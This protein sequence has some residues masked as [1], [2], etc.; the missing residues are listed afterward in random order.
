M[1]DLPNQGGDCL[2]NLPNEIMT[3]IMQYVVDD[4]TIINNLKC[5]NKRMYHIYDNIQ[6]HAFY[7]EFPS[8]HDLNWYKLYNIGCTTRDIFM[9][10]LTTIETSYDEKTSYSMIH[11]NYPLYVKRNSFGYYDIIPDYWI[12]EEYVDT[13]MNVHIIRDLYEGASY[14]VVNMKNT[15]YG[16]NVN[17]LMSKGV[18]EWIDMDTIILQ[19][20]A[21]PIDQDSAEKLLN[22]LR[23][24]GY[25]EINQNKT[26]L[27]HYQYTAL[28]TLGL[29]KHV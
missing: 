26:S 6:K 4:N 24:R 12:G 7:K 2:G 20:K 18:S 23:K 5:V 25:V 15:S 9:Q 1:D 17:N 22:E 28:E 19:K 10:D 29:V 8:K 27:P 11:L 16:V 14:V 13:D 3:I 21:Q